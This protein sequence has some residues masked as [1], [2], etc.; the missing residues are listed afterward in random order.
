MIDLQ[1]IP[2]SRVRLAYELTP[3]EADALVQA[4]CP[5]AVF[6]LELWH[7]AY[8][9]FWKDYA[10][11]AAMRYKTECLILPDVALTPGKR[12]FTDLCGFDVMDFFK[13][14]SR[15]IDSKVLKIGLEYVLSETFSTVD[16][17]YSEERDFLFTTLRKLEQRGPEYDIFAIENIDDEVLFLPNSSYHFI[18]RIFF[19][20]MLV[21]RAAAILKLH[22]FPLRHELKGLT[23]AV[24]DSILNTPQQKIPNVSIEATPAAQQ[25][26]EVRPLEPQEQDA[27]FVPRSAWAGKTKE[28]IR[29]ALRGEGLADEYIVHILLHK[30][31]LR[32][33]KRA[34]GE[35]LGEP[36]KSDSAYDKQGKE[37]VE[38]AM[39]VNVL[40]A[41]EN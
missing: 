21:D 26:A 24:V 22:D 17:I 12:F 18:S 4:L 9:R 37:L 7:R 16:T 32:L 29:D 6:P 40:D 5:D 13:K 11:T 35:L 14:L 38:K 31:G 41:P 2:M 27:I 25:T 30:R 33:T 34:I 23:H 1:K 8:E 15:C 20:T 28:A 19:D 10:Q 3:Y 36:H 39:C